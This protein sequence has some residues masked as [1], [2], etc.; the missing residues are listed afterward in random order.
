MR[1]R[2]AGRYLGA[3]EHARLLEAG[4]AASAGRTPRGGARIG[5]VGSPTADG[6]LYDLIEEAGT[7]VADPHP[8]GLAWPPPVPPA[9]PTSLD[10]ILRAATCN[11]LDPRS[12]PVAAHRRA[13]VDACVAARCDLVVFQLDEH[14]D[15]FGWDLPAIRDSL[16][17]AGI[18]AVDLGFRPG[19][20]DPDWREQVR[21]QLRTAGPGR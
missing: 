13:V 20:D 3:G 11:A 2:N 6:W 15:C 18:A 9:G 7:I 4:V 8:Y 14:D 1:W 5:L 12:L 21:V 19:W 10:A 17:E 16:E